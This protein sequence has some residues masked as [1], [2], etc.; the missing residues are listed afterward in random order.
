MIF[1]RLNWFKDK[2]GDIFAIYEGSLYIFK[3]NLVK[4]HYFM[5]HLYSHQCFKMVESSNQILYVPQKDYVY[6]FHP[7]DLKK[8][9]Y[10]SLN[11]P[12]MNEK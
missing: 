6:Y 4:K 1:S 9:F 3:Y 5:I 12:S 8:S 11:R 10:F 7:K 2:F